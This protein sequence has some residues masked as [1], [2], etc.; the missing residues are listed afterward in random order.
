MFKIDIVKPYPTMLGPRTIYHA[1]ASTVNI[2]LVDQGD[3]K[4]D[5]FTQSYLRVCCFV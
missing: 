4:D 5:F 3:T 1:R 2:R